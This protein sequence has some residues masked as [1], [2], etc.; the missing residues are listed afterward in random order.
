MDSLK[1]KSSHSMKTKNLLAKA[2]KL[3]ES[4]TNTYRHGAIVVKNGTIVAMGINRS[5]NNP[6]QVQFPK[7]QASVHAEVAALIACRKTDLRGATIYVARICKDGS[8]AMS[9]PCINCQKALVERGIKK[10]YYTID[11]EMDL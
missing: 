5:V 11:S 8:Q 3:A 2:S 7:L 1:F 6:D 4:S 9:K 10:V